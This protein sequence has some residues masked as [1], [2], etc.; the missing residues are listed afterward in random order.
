MRGPSLVLSVLV[1]AA[2]SLVAPF[3]NASSA[4]VLHGS[5]VAPYEFSYTDC[6]FPVDGTGLF[7]SPHSMGR[8]G[9]N[10]D[11]GAFFGHDRYTLREVHT[12]RDTGAVVV[13][14]A[15]GLLHDVQA[16]RISGSVFEF[17]MMDV[18]THQFRTLEGTLLHQERGQVRRTFLFDTLGDSTPGGEFIEMLS[19]EF[20]GN[21]PDFDFCATFD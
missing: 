11:A 17:T 5:D 9:K 7:N 15:K 16:T 19:E 21:F 1:L 4:T 14:T 2:G 18:G 3:G 20:H 13:I 8:V 6:G 12:R 10:D